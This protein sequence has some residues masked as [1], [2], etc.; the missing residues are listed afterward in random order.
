[1]PQEILEHIAYFAATDTFLGP[2][3]GLVPLLAVDRRT[4]AALSMTA[5]PYLWSRIFAAK[6]DL[7]S[8]LRRL[9][10]AGRTVGPAE[11][12]EELK[13][14]C[15][16]LRTVRRRTDALATSYTL[17]PTHRDALRSVLWLA[18]LMMLENDGANERQLREYAQ[19]D[20]WLRDF[21]F[22]QQGASLAA[23]SV[24]A[25]LWPPNDER[26]ALALWLFWYLLKPGE[27]RCS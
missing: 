13:L 11:I 5:N 18:Y 14:R 4:H 12:C 23:W 9:A 8:P 6:F 15:T 16:L 27:C 25:D 10:A 26:A 20:V 19:F 21:L 22:H 7:A 3:D 1:M 24:N 2:P 17:S